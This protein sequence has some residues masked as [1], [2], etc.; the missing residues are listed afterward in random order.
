MGAPDGQAEG[1]GEDLSVSREAREENAQVS[2][3]ENSYLAEA[4]CLPHAM[5]KGYNNVYFRNMSKQ[6]T[7]GVLHPN[8]G[9]NDQG[10]PESLW[11]E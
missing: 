5:G 1:I 2:Q 11:G 6:E 3:M 10:C 7:L 4:S 9:N 8:K